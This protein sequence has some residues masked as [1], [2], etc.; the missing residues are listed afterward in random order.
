[1]KLASYRQTATDPCR[2]SSVVGRRGKKAGGLSDG[3]I[4]WSLMRHWMGA[5]GRKLTTPK[6]STLQVNVPEPCD[7]GGSGDDRAASAAAF[8]HSE[9]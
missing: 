2:F 6:K 8:A 7:R 1:M 4:S 5:R 3:I 9:S